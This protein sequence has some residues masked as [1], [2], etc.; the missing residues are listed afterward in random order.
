MHNTGPEGGAV[1]HHGDQ[2]ERTCGANVTAPPSVIVNGN[3]DATFQVRLD[4][5]ATSVGGGT[6]FQDIGGYIQLT[7]SNSRLN[8]NVKLSIPYYLV[9]HSRSALTVSQSGSTLNFGNPN[10]ALTAF[11]SFYTWGLSQTTPQGIAQADVR[12]VGASVS[13]SNVIFGINTHNRT[14]TTLGFQEFDICID[15]SGGTGFT[16]NKILIGINGSALSTSL[17][18]STFATAIFPTDANLRHQWLRHDLFTITQPTDNS[19]LLM[20]VP[21]AGTT[22]L[23][24]TTASPRF[25]YK[26]NYYGTDGIGAQMPG[27]GSFNAIAPAVTFTA[28][29]AVAVEWFGV[30]DGQRER[31]DRHTPALGLMVL[32]PDNVSG[33][34][35]AALLPL[36]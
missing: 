1:Q 11:P 21:V 17:A 14:S 19:T 28:A 13:G 34:R 30:G 24:L 15:T 3:S 20:P 18:A 10:G 26:L 29:P 22:G 16:P 5:P 2:D 23:G 32:A 25:K 33:A 12:A 9:A 6:G 4:V 31:R 27:I 35:Q 7:P 8:G 36:P